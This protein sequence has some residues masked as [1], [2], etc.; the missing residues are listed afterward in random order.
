MRYTI[1]TPS[2]AEPFIEKTARAIARRPW[3]V[4]IV[5][6]VLTGLAAWG[7]SNLTIYTA[8]NA[9]FPKYIDVYQRLESYLQKFGAVSE[10]VIV[11]EDAPQADLREFATELAAGFNK[12]P[13]VK[14]AMERFDTRFVL[15]HGYLLVPPEQLSQFTSVLNGFAGPNAVTRAAEWDEA[16]EEAAH[17]LENPPPLSNGDSD[18]K[19][20]ER[21]LSLLLFFFKQWYRFLISQEI[22]ASIPWHELISHP[23]AKRLWKGE[24]T[25]PPVTGMPSFC[26]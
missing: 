23:G 6:C 5:V 15:E 13:E 8:R 24:D 10:L 26:L 11:V 25:L 20:T 3:R 14:H 22:P 16:L 9:L 7:S 17:W 4:L 18:L 19:T 2:S 12:R 21:R 1:T